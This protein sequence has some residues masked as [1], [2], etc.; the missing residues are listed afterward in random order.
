MDRSHQ[1]ELV[2]NLLRLNVK[3]G[4]QLVRRLREYFFQ[5]DWNVTKFMVMTGL[6][7]SIYNKINNGSLKAISF[8]SITAICIGL[9]LPYDDAREV[10]KLA[11]YCLN[12]FPYAQA[13]NQLLQE[14]CDIAEANEILIAAH[15][16]PLTK[17]NVA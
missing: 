15:F 3:K 9:N 12:D 16:S 2:A 1:Q 4:N 13:C 10:V 17:Q 6:S 11:G 5:A 14:E 7:D 8:K